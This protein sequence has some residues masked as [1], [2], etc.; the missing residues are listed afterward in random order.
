MCVCPPLN[1]N[2]RINSSDNPPE[3]SHSDIFHSSIF[4]YKYHWC[5]IDVLFHPWGL[6]DAFIPTQFCHWW[7]TFFIPSKLTYCDF[8]YFLSFTT[9][10]SWTFVIPWQF[11]H[12]WMLFSVSS[13]LSLFNTGV[14]TLLISDESS[15]PCSIS[16]C[17]ISLLFTDEHFLVC[18]YSSFFNSLH[19][20]IYP[21]LGTIAYL[22]TPTMCFL[23]FHNCRSASPFHTFFVHNGGSDICVRSV[24]SI[25]IKR[26]T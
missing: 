19:S 26:I 6:T 5:L 2:D 20:S 23:F 21:L 9:D 12:S 15:P 7:I 10:I 17:F 13:F 25:V 16:S 22:F 1:L 11:Y 24:L 4:L 18:I 3:P 14:Q 8:L